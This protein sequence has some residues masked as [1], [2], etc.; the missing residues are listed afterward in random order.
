MGSAIRLVGKVVPVMSGV[1]A[2]LKSEGVA[3]MVNAQGERAAA[4]CNAMAQRL[5]RM[6]QAPRYEAEPVQTR[7]V[8]ASRVHIANGE[9][10]VD[11]LRNNTLKK[12]CGV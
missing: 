11:N 3:A 4:R 5:K 2:V 9:A 1:N 7:Y 10:Y 6:K 8:A 12:G